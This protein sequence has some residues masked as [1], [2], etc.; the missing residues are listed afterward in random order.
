MKEDGMVR[1]NVTY[2]V[3]LA[4][5]TRRGVESLRPST[6]LTRRVVRQK[7]RTLRIS[8]SSGHTPTP[9]LRQSSRPRIP[10]MTQFAFQA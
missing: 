10:G 5:P 7:Q 6:T 4:F 3:G 2:S 8:S 1:G 9:T